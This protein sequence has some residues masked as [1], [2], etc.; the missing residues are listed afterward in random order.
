MRECASL[1][2]NDGIG[3]RLSQHFRL[4]HRLGADDNVREDGTEPAAKAEEVKREIISLV[5]FVIIMNSRS[6]RSGHVVIYPRV[7]NDD[8]VF[9]RYGWFN[10]IDKQKII[11]KCGIKVL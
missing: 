11:T 8:K 1:L 2:V 6:D 3:R 4:G 7:F 10:S 9:W 5:L